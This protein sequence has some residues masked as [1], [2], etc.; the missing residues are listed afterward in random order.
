MNIKYNKIHSNNSSLH[1]IGEWVPTPTF[2]YRNHLYKK[3]ISGSQDK[4]FLDIG[5]GNGYF[6]KYLSDNE[7]FGIATDVSEKAIV[8]AKKYLP[9]K[10]KIK[11]K[12][13]DFYKIRS[14][15]KYDQIF[16]F[17]VL[18]HV[19][20]EKKFVKQIS[21]VLKINGRLILSVPAHMHEWN[22]TDDLKGH[23][24]RF[25]KKELKKLLKDSGF[26]IVHFWS[27]GFPLLSI[28]R[29][30]NKSGSFIKQHEQKNSLNLTKESS[31]VQEYNPKFKFLVN[32]IMLT[33]AFIFMDLFLKTDLGFGYAVEATKK[34]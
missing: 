5:S 27:Y 9:K 28:L 3:L 14:V 10:S 12:L 8:A 29:T 17:E 24:R 19:P 34:K 6:L 16:C 32:P 15:K 21:N 1:D 7:F 26:Q 20:D 18:E 30:I 25:E 23:L 4:E 33:P 13:A 22:K 11:L 31:I 2:L